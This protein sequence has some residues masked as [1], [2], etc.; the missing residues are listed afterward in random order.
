MHETFFSSRE[1]AEAWARSGSGH[2]LGIPVRGSGSPRTIFGIQDTEHYFRR[3][4]SLG[5]FGGYASPGWENYLEQS[6]VRGVLDRLRGVRTTKIVWNVR[7]DHQPLAAVLESLGLEPVSIPT[8][9][10]H[11]QEDYDMVFAGYNATMRNHVRRSRKMG[12]RLRDGLEENDVRAFY[13]VYSNLVQQK[14]GFQLALPVELFINLLRT[15]KSARLVLA[16]VEE[17]VV[18][19]GFFLKDGCTVLYYMGASDRDYSKY[20]PS[21]AVMDEAIRWACETGA[22]FFNFGSSGD[23]EKLKQFKSFWGAQEENSWQFVWQ[24]PFW[25]RIS[26]WKARFARRQAGL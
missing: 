9:V 14:P 25:N 7:F 18:A 6:T 24:N 5:P 15:G 3:S 10:L 8:H 17:E 22:D 2:V 4:I 16:E 1:F 13:R 21:C 23:L 19:G 20:F 12:V 26:Q 11:L